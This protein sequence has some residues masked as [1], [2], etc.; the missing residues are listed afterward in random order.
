MS[1]YGLF[2][3]GGAFFW[4]AGGELGV[5]GTV[6]WVDGGDWGSVGHYFGWMEVGRNIFLLAVSGS[7]CTI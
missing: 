7:G 4:V 5:D 1:E 3:V 2:W 6:F